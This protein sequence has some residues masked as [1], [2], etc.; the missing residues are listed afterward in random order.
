MILHTL[1][2]KYTNDQ[3]I[4]RLNSL[5]DD[6]HDESYLHALGEIR[7]LIP[8]LCTSGMVISVG[9]VK[10]PLDDNVE[11]FA[12]DGVVDGTPYS[13]EFEPWSNWLGMEVTYDGCDDL[14]ALC[15]SL[16]EMTFMG[17]SQETIDNE[18]EKLYDTMREVEEAI[19]SGDTSK[20]LTLDDLLAEL[21]DD[22]E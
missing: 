18:R 7:N 9:K 3:I 17:Y 22:E 15:Y 11:Y 8:V 2:N 20:F 16:W 13:I 6:I 1:I 19:A 5:Y 10:D 14:D 21:E 4:E 12:V